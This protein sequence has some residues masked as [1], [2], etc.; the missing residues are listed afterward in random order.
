M[1]VGPEYKT[2]VVAIYLLTIVSPEIILSMELTRSCFVEAHHTRICES[3]GG[4]E[5]GFYIDR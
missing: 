1:S 3:S 2:R 5:G 4:L